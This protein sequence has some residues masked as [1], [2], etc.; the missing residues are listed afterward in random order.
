[1]IVDTLTNYDKW[2]IYMKNAE[3]P[4]LYL[5]Y[6]YYFMI[7]AALQRRVWIPKDN[8]QCFPNVYFIFVGGP[9]VGKGRVIKQIMEFMKHHTMKKKF[10]TSQLLSAKTRE[11]MIDAAEDIEDTAKNNDMPLFPTSPDST[12]LRN[13]T[14]HLAGAYRTVRVKQGDKMMPY[15]HSSSAFLLEELASLVKETTETRDLM[16]FLLNAWDCGDYNHETHTSGKDR[17]RKMCVS[18]LAGCTP[19]FIREKLGDG[20]MDEGIKARTIFLCAENARKR[21]WTVGGMTDDQLKAK[22]DLLNW[23]LELSKLYGPVNF[24]EEANEWLRVW[25]E[26]ERWMPINRVNKDSSLDDYYARKDMHLMKMAMAVHFSD[27][28]E[29]E[30]TLDEVLKAKS[31]L[32]EA[33]PAMTMALLRKPRNTLSPVGIAIRKHLEKFGRM[34]KQELLFEF[35]TDVREVELDEVMKFLL[36]TKQIKQLIEDGKTFYEHVKKEKK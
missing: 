1:M 15:G 10:D 35:I 7:S 11:A 5:K 12:T 6:G 14:H 8:Q 32:E 27:T 2:M 9:A 21:V 13:L 34:T 16:R 4:D 3:S 24:T 23:I 30:I 28:L 20:I 33:E 26:H 18:L 29:G 36:E 17:I 31:I 25:H 22:E 19:V